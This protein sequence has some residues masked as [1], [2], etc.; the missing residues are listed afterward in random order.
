MTEQEVRKIAHEAAE[1]AA[2]KAVRETLLAL[3]ID[4][5]EPVEFQSRMVFVRS[6]QSAAAT[7]GR[8][9]LTV[10][11]GTMVL[12][13]LYAMWDKVGGPPR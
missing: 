2:K 1:L 12:G 7:V 5:D 11:I 3:G 9:S 13:V 10:V 6:L 8:Q 4:A